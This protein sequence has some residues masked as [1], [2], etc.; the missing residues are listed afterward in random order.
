[1]TTAYTR[2]WSGISWTPLGDVTGR[3][4]G[5]PTDGV[6]ILY[7]IQPKGQSNQV[8]FQQDS[9]TWLQ[10]QKSETPWRNEVVTLK[11]R[12]KME[13]FRG[14]YSYLI[15]NKHGA[16]NLITSGIQPFIRVD[17]TN[18]VY[19]LNVSKPILI[20]ARHYEMSV[21]FLNLANTPTT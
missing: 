16:V 1:M 2:Y 9:R 13:N 19:I 6:E 4:V 21:T 7:P 10:S 11:Y 12:V 17:Q 15:D 8:A 20:L 14:F 3:D 5:I 18:S